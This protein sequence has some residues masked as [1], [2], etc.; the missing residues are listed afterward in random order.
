MIPV[1]LSIAAAM[2]STAQD[3]ATDEE[4]AADDWA[5]TLGYAEGD[6]APDTRIINGE[7]ATKDDWPMAGGML[8]TGS[9]N[10]NGQNLDQSTM[11]CSS[12]LIAPDVVMLAAHCLELDALTMQL[13]VEID[14]PEFHWTRK[15]NLTAYQ[16]GAPASDLPADV[17]NVVGTASH[18][19]FSLLGV[20]LGLSE[21]FD[22][23]LMFLDEP[24][25][26]VPLGYL[27]QADTTEVE[28]EV[29]EP[30]VVVGWGMQSNVPQGQQ[31]PPNS[32]GLKMMGI[33]MVA[34]KS[35]YEF[36]VG[37][38]ESDVRKCNGDSGGPS[39]LE[40]DTDS[41]DPWR[42]VGITSHS[43]DLTNCAVTGG[44]DT[45]VSR[46]L[47]WIDQEMRAACAD[48]TRT[49]CEIEGIIPPPAADGTFAWEPAPIEEEETRKACGCSSTAA[50]TAGWM[51]LGLLA[52][53]RRRRQ[54]VL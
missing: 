46:Y 42:V 22:V 49:W 18:P 7:E 44:V 54:E 20:Q 5:D 24:V 14:N 39:F 10:F 40:V 3:A 45:R 2:P 1:L 16:L 9:I 11:L 25:L 35:P 52:L 6:D 15:R 27:P 4:W 36:K 38:A 31:P 48:G 41:T 50:G 13:G 23:A 8:L 30:L 32:F 43:Y 28:L 26:D 33:S 37:E 47:E 51:G 12:T 17:R 21:N 53:I 19:D 34:E 29:G